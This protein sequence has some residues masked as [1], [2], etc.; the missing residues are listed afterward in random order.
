MTG[1]P[2][3]NVVTAEEF[4]SLILAVLRLRSPDQ[5]EALSDIELDRRLERAYR[6]L[7]EAGETL[8]V[9]PNFTFYCDPM[10][11]NSARARDAVLAA[12]RK[13]MLQLERSGNLKYRLRLSQPQA[14]SLLAR[15]SIEPDFL[16]SLVNEVF[17]KKHARDGA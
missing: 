6:R 16:R 11:G 1:L 2:T 15:S 14:Q 7:S 9:Q 13:G 10:H 5:P 4:L 8:G 3:M 17:P 12:L